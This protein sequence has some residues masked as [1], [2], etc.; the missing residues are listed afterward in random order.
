MSLADSSQSLTS[1]K[2]AVFEDESSYSTGSSDYIAGVYADDLRMTVA[3]GSRKLS[4]LAVD[5]KY[6]PVGLSDRQEKD[7]KFTV[8]DKA[9]AQIDEKTL[10]VTALKAGFTHITVQYENFSYT[11]ALYV[12]ENE[13]AAND[14]SILRVEP[15]Q[16]SAYT[17]SLSYGYPKQIRAMVYYADGSFKEI[18]KLRFNVSDPSVCAVDS[19]GFI[20]VKGMGTTEVT[21][22]YKGEEVFSVSVTVTE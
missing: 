6:T 10:V 19:S 18:S 20:R 15:S 1:V 7:L 14:E 5:G 17:I 13:D 22:K 2:A 16:T 21:V 11:C 3:D 12:Y 9:I 8:W 4:V